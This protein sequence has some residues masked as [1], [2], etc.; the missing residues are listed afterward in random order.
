MLLSIVNNYVGFSFL[1]GCDIV[2]RNN[3]WTKEEE[4]KLR[5]VYNMYDMDTIKK[6]FP[7]HKA[8][9][10][11]AHKLGINRKKYWQAHKSELVKR[12]L[13]QSEQV[14][15]PKRTLSKQDK[16][17]RHDD[18]TYPKPKNPNR[19]A[20][21]DWYTQEDMEFI[22]NNY[23]SM[24]DEEMGKCLKRSAKSVQAKRLQLGIKRQGTASY[25][26]LQD[27]VRANNY[28]WKLKSMQNCHYKCVLSGDRFDEIHHIVGLNVILNIALCALGYDL[29]DQNIYNASYYSDDELKQL[30]YEFRKIQSTYPLGVCLR[31]D[32]H[33]NF[34]KH[35]GYGNNTIQQWE[36]F[37]NN[38]S[39]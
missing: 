5:E 25:V 11:K 23:M 35:Y 22:V 38:Y 8:I 18:I 14:N 37:V 28:K 34:H 1:Y 33:D 6:M 26:S 21:L 10:S 20:R 9:M 32:I 39:M 36:Q 12:Q 16:S 2:S 3:L 24:T 27:F 13:Q 7:N 19:K 4:K 31:K 29:N 17:L 15:I 30:L